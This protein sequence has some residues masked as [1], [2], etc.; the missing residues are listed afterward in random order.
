LA[1]RAP[2]QEEILPMLNDLLP[3]KRLLRVM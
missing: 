1:R 2:E 3:P